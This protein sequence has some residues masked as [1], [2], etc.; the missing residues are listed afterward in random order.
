MYHTVCVC[1]KAVTIETITL[2]EAQYNI[3]YIVITISDYNN[4]SVYN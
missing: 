4:N 2:K 1:V 3:Y